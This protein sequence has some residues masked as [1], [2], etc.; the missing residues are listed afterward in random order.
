MPQPSAFSKPRRSC[1]LCASSEFGACDQAAVDPGRRARA[2]RIEAAHRDDLQAC[3]PDLAPARTGGRCARPRAR[4]SG[5]RAAARS[6]RPDARSQRSSR[7]RSASRPIRAAAEQLQRPLPGRPRRREQP[8][9]D[10]AGRARPRSP[11]A[12]ARARGRSRRARRPAPAPW[13]GR[14]SRRGPAA[15]FGTASSRQA[16][17]ARDAGDEGVVDPVEERLEPRPAAGVVVD[18]RCS[19]CRRWRR[20]A[21]GPRRRR[22]PATARSAPACRRTRRSSR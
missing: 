20:A 11:R 21:R 5:A 1:R 10:R 9:L 22:C 4:L 6:A 13:P 2:Q 8:Q 7:G 3:D 14:R 19:T 15:A 12:R 16:A 18:A 17:A